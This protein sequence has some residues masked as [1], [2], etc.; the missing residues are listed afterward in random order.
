MIQTAPLK[1]NLRILF[2]LAL[3]ILFVGLFLRNSDLDKVSGII[4]S[5]RLEWL[6]LG[7]A[8]N[9][10]ALLCRTLRWRT[11][12]N[13]E[14]PPPFYATLFANAVGYM[15]ST[16]LPIR[17]GDVARPALLSRRTDVKFATALGT[18][19]TE[20]ILDLLAI[21]SLFLYFV[22]VSSAA[23]SADPRTATKFLLVKSAAVTAAVIV[24]AMLS[25]LAAML[26][27]SSKIRR[28]HEFFGRRLPARVRVGWMRFFDSFSYSLRLSRH[29]YALFKVLALTACIW[30]CLSGQFYF[31]LLALGH[32]LPFTASFFISGITI[33]GLMIPTPGGVGGFHKACQ[34]ALTNFYHFD[35]NSSIAVALVVHV[36]GITPVVLIGIT[37]FL[38]EGLSWRQITKMEEAAELE[39][40]SAAA[41]RPEVVAVSDPNRS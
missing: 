14:R 22:M 8:C 3:T 7:F 1:R 24:T 31:S 13:P 27:F 30:M 41:E 17:A 4:R 12:L 18:V 39:M 21:L 11:I 25:F 10:G 35:V 40:Q 26:L 15:L 2:I 34:I 16:V 28:L 38:R 20:K 32:P 5:T 29:R 23:F 19:L 36:V 33:I 6:A 37:L 9:I